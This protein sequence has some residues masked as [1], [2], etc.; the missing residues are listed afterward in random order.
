MR[1]TRADI[2]VFVKRGSARV[3]RCGN[4]CSSDFSVEPL[5]SPPSEAEQ[6]KSGCDNDN[7][8]SDHDK[9]TG[10]GTG[11]IEER[12]AGTTSVCALV[13]SARRVM[14]IDSDG[15]NLTSRSGDESR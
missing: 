4:G 12:T 3:V 13:K 11:V 6:T 9:D 2:G 10:D 5:P 15:V 8:Q 14:N 1:T 7:D